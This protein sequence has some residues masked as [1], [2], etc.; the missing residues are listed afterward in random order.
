VGTLDRARLET[1]LRRGGAIVEPAPGQGAV[2]TWRD[3]AGLGADLRAGAAVGP[4]PG[5]GNVNVDAHLGGTAVGLGDG[6]ILVGDPSLVRRALAVR[7]GEGK[8]ARQGALVNELVAVDAN[9]VTWGVAAA[10]SYLDSFAPGVA[11]ARFH[12]ALYGVARGSVSLRAEFATHDQ[13]IAFQT[14]LV[15]FLDDTA[16]LAGDTAVGKALARVK[17]GAE[18]GVEGTTLTVLA[19]L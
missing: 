5:W 2:F 6:L 12:A 1:A 19:L 14:S 16:K 7:A 15:K 4:E 9:A 3:P 10:G 18:I 13:A 11:H 8:D 17:E